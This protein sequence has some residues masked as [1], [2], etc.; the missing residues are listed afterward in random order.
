MSIPAGFQLGLEL[1]NIL[2]PI[3]QAVSSSG[4]LA[5]VD[6]IRKAGSDSI[7]E[8][9]LASL[10]GRHRIDDVIKF[11]FREI[12]AK[13]DQSFISRYIDI[14]LESGAGPTVQEAL[15]SKNQA[16]FSMVIQLSGLT[17]A[18]E[19]ES[20]ALAIVE[21]IDRIVRESGGDAGIVPD[22]VAL[23]GTIRACQE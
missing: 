14:V 10:L 19:H 2:N 12:V 3:S 5:L 6:A 21:A 23:L 16:M 9:K 4:S 7:T 18:H 1:T 17:F 11:H 20:F 22:Y 15:K 8:T 13:S